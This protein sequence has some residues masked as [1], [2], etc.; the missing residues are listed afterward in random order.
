MIPADSDRPRVTRFE[1]Q[2]P[3]VPHDFGIIHRRVWQGLMALTLG[4]GAQYIVW[5]W[6]KS[7]NMDAL[8]LSVPLALAETLAFAGL[9]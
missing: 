1:R 4:F 8:W 9:I 5:R 7:L 2:E 3:W 6:T